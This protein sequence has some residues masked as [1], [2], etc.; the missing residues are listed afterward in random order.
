[1]SEKTNIAWCD[2]TVNPWRGCDKVSLGCANCYITTTTPFRTS[3]Q[4]HGDPRV[5]SKSAIKDAL[6]LNR[7]PWICEACG[8][9]F[10]QP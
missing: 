5:K 2:S 9:G 1:M 10:S 7:K 4:K 8:N 6:A 3:G